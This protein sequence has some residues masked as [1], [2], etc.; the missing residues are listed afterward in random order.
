M[1]FDYLERYGSRIAIYTADSSYSYAQLLDFAEQISSPIK[2][3]EFN[4]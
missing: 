1:I 3:G 4:I 2:S